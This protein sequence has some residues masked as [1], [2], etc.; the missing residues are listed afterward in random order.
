MRRTD[1]TLKAAITGLEQPTAHTATTTNFELFE[2]PGETPLVV[3][4]FLLQHTSDCRLD[5]L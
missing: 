3:P 2:K 5:P 4:V 1:N